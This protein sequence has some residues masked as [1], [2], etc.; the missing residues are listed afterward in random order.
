MNHL[1]VGFGEIGQAINEILETQ[2]D[3]TIDIH[4]PL[5]LL[6]GDAT[7]FLDI[8]H[9][10]FPYTKQF[11]HDVNNYIEIFNPVHTIIYSTVPI[12][13][14]KKIEGAVYSPIEGRLSDLALSMRKRNLA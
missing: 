2:K 4:D 8:M 5:A 3:V 14:I 9:V 10:C 1:I 7:R 11:V 12:G 6:Q 13:T